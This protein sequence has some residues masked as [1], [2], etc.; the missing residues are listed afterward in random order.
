MILRSIILNYSTTIFYINYHTEHTTSEVFNSINFR[1]LLYYRNIY[2]YLPRCEKQ[3][4]FMNGTNLAFTQ[5]TPPA[6]SI[7][8]ICFETPFTTL[9]LKKIIKQKIKQ[10]Q[11]RRSVSCPVKVIYY[12][13]ICI[14]RD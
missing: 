1:Y 5:H 13:Q 2:H 8:I 6:I 7:F 14:Q 9:A 3:Q 11:I 4:I 12:N 10:M